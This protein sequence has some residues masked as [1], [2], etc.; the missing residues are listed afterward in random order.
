MKRLF[1]ILFAAVLACGLFTSCEREVEPGWNNK[2]FAILDNSCDNQVCLTLLTGGNSIATT[3]MIAPHEKARLTIPPGRL[4][5]NKVVID[6]QIDSTGT[7]QQI[8]K[9]PM[10]PIEG[11]QFVVYT[12]NSDYSVNESW[13]KY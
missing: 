8:Y 6:M 10:H 3:G 5:T 9:N 12:V 13:G 1:I 7:T 11:M 4:A 2:P